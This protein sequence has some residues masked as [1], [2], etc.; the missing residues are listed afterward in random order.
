VLA[1]WAGWIID[2]CFGGEE[3]REAPRF[4]SAFILSRLLMTSTGNVGC[5]VLN[6]RSRPWV[7][8]IIEAPGE[9]FPAYRKAEVMNIRSDLKPALLGAVGGA[10]AL[11]IIGFTWG[12]WVTGSSAETSA[13]QSATAAVVAVLAP[14]CVDQFQRSVDASVKQAELLKISAWQQGSYVEKGGW[15]T[16]PGSTTPD[17][18]VAK[19]CA[20]LITNLKL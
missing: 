14:I 9:F 19:A 16:M 11:A 8:D 3:N 1:A 12:G 20:G 7:Y 13:K 4:W 15:A 18:A 5:A 2:L 6:S 10:A 17:L